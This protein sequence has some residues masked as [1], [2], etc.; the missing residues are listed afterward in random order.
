MGSASL[1]LSVACLLMVAGCA[2]EHGRDGGES[3]I[4]LTSIPVPAQE[5]IARA[6]GSGE[7]EKIVKENED[8]VTAYEAEFEVN[9]VDHTVK[10]DAAGAILEEEVEIAVKD[11]PAAVVAAIKARYANA[12]MEEATMVTEGSKSFYEVSVEVGKKERELKVD[13]AGAI[14][15]DEAD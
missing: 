9:D 8:G 3:K 1:K 5:A 4:A 6:V 12:E 11:L 10:V 14:L 13:A 2:G 7:L 15:E